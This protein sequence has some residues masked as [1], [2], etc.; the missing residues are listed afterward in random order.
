VGGSTAPL[1]IQYNVWGE[2]MD[3][4]VQGYFTVMEAYV[5]PEKY[6]PPAQAGAGPLA[7]FFSAAAAM[8]AAARHRVTRNTKAFYIWP[9]LLRAHAKQVIQYVKNKKCGKIKRDY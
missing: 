6:S 9:P 5:L 3:G 1:N 8:A 2:T 7:N 4:D